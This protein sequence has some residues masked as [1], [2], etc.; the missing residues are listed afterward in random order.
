MYKTSIWD[1]EQCLLDGND[2]LLCP[3]LKMPFIRGSI[4]NMA[5]V[6]VCVLQYLNV[7]FVRG[8]M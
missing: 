5:Y 1:H 3:L 4:S 7:T 6:C 2:I 8:T